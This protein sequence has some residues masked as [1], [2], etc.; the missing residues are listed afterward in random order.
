MYW[1]RVNN[2]SYS[3]LHGYRV[4][5]VRVALHLLGEAQKI[6]FTTDVF[7]TTIKPQQKVVTAQDVQSSLYYLHLDSVDDSRFLSS[8]EALDEDQLEDRDIRNVASLN[9]TN[10]VRRKPLP[11]SS[12]RPEHPSRTVS[13]L[14]RVNGG[15]QERKPVG[16]SA[17]AGYPLSNKAAPRPMN[18]R[19][20]PDGSSPPEYSHKKPNGDLRRWSERP[21]MTLPKL[22]PRPTRIQKRDARPTPPFA[23]RLED[24]FAI[25]GS[26]F[27][28]GQ[29]LE[30]DGRDKSLGLARD[31][32]STGHP[33]DAS[34][35]LIRRYNG[36]QWNVG[37]ILNNDM[38][39]VTSVHASSGT[40]ISI[41]IQT[42]GYSRLVGI[43][44]TEA[45]KEDVEERSCFERH[46]RLSSHIE[47][48]DQSRQLELFNLMLNQQGIRPSYDLPR[49]N[50]QSLGGNEP[51]NSP[52]FGSSEHRP[53]T[54]NVFLLQSPWDGVCEFTTGI[55]GRA[56]KC[57]HFY[58]SPDPR[59]GPG[60]HSAPVSELRFNL[61]SSR[62][63]G[64]PRPKSPLIE[65]PRQTK[66]SS[67]F[68]S[69]ASRRFSSSLEATKTSDN[70]LLGPKIEL[71]DRLDLSLGQEHA[72]GGFSGRQAKLGKLIVEKEG[73]LML[74][75]IVAANMALWWR[76]Y[77]KLT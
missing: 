19:L 18:P 46:L 62:T 57:K 32:S 44:E 47:R 6:S 28:R 61:P 64:T 50:P 74:D 25:D 13:Q 52:T 37:I 75:L 31:E 65:S 10:N 42:P 67:F 11:S 34:L 17:K 3:T 48:W 22:P 2:L 51:V 39:A 8:V 68:S 20:Y 56:F 30:P 27:S 69:H 24:S 45:R 66:R 38:D 70:G 16:Q 49:N 43:S 4:A 54:R 71:E 58:T 59:F 1:K 77:E 33:S 36:Q 35:V 14:Q 29:Y 7:L 26:S 55:A 23:G 76:V 60:M 9:V 12:S 40:G 53:R 21:S 63:F 41:Q 5:R 15:T 73:L 72:G